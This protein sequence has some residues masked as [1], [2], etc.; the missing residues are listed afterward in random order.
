MCYVGHGVSLGTYLGEQ[1]AKEILG[2]AS[3]NPFGGLKMPAVPIYWGNPWFVDAV[4][5]WYHILDKFG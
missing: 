2:E 5:G 3:F 1:I 4:Q